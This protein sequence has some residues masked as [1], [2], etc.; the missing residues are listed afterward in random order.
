M[1]T[2]AKIGM[3]PAELAEVSTRLEEAGAV[4]T[5]RWTVE[6]FGSGAALACSFQ[7]CVIVDLAVKVDPGLEVVF[8]DTGFH[9]PETLEF[10]EVVRDLY[11]LNLT[12]T[13]PRADAD[14]W[15]CGTAEC[16][17]RRKVGPLFRALEGKSAWLTGLKR[18]DAATRSSTQV[19]AWDEARQMV[20]VNPLAAWTDD[21]IAGYVSAHRLPVHSL[22]AQG[23]LSIGC[24]PTTRPVQPGEDPRA[25]RWSGSDKTECGLHS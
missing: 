24:A 17:P 15:P 23:Y 11:R 12:V 14:P 22:L 1:A 8:L 4:E 20:K 25:G 21:D 19:V 10:V 18:S 7:D 2:I 6:R 9:F 5:I 16:C 13:H 3:D